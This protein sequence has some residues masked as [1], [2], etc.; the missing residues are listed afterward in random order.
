MAIYPKLIVVQAKSLLLILPR[1]ELMINLRRV[2]RMTLPAL[3]RLFNKTCVSLLYKQI[4]FPLSFPAAKN[5]QIDSNLG[6]DK[7]IDSR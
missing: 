6:I 7:Q 3:S 4:Y 5:K 2:F 1:L